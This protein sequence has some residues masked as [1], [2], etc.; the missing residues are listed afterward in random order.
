M[1]TDGLLPAAVVD[2]AKVGILIGGFVLEFGIPDAFEVE[3]ATVPSG[4]KGVRVVVL[5]TVIEGLGTVVEVVEYERA[6]S[7]IRPEVEAASGHGQ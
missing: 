5:N 2:V 4:I 3:G 7:T 1:V 6:E